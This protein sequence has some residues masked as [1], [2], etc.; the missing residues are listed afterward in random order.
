[1]EASFS[2]SFHIAKVRY[3]LHKLFPEIERPRST[4]LE[5]NVNMVFL[6]NLLCS[7]YICIQLQMSV[8]RFQANR[9]INI[10]YI[11]IH[12]LFFFFQKRVISFANEGIFYTWKLAVHWK[13]RRELNNYSN[14]AFEIFN[15]KYL[16]FHF[17]LRGRG[18]IS[19][20]G[21]I[22]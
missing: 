2:P 19:H 7:K 1:M 4:E 21:G 15:V 9:N 3:S 14:L 22:R 20:L 6:L 12:L 10:D 5:H 18:K 13:K 16:A 8:I 11:T 17:N